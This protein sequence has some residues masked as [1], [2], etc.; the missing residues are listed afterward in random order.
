MA[1]VHGHGRVEEGRMT[2]AAT[3]AAS[4]V[5]ARAEAVLAEVTGTPWPRSREAVAMIG[6]AR[7]YLAEALDEHAL[8][9]SG[10]LDWSGYDADLEWFGGDPQQGAIEA[11]ETQ[12]ADAARAV[13]RVLAEY[14][15][16]DDGAS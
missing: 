4:P 9:V 15:N 1:R 5:I 6:M 7:D 11:A 2:A 8:L 13:V 14:R 10:A 3:L 16:R 12:A